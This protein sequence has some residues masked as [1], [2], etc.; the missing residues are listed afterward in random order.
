MRFILLIFYR[1]TSMEAKGE[2]GAVPSSVGILEK[3]Y[4]TASAAAS[5][6][7]MHQSPSSPLRQPSY[8]NQIPPESRIPSHPVPH[9]S[10]N[11]GPFRPPG[12]S[13]MSSPFYYPNL[14]PNHSLARLPTPHDYVNAAAKRLNE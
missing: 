7:A 4:P 9:S 14:S 8:Y 3:P 1:I 12:A 2:P 6:I 5:L 13:S 11:L 10:A